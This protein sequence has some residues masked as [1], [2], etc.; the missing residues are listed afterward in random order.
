MKKIIFGAMAA[1][2]LLACSKDQVIEQNRANDEIT[3]S[4]VAENQTKA[5]A[6][7][8]NNNQPGSFNVYANHGGKAYIDGDVIEKQETSWVNTSGVRYWPESGNVTFFAHVNADGKFVGNTTA[9]TI[10]DF[11]VPTNVAAQKDLLYAVKSQ[12]KGNNPVTLNFRHAL[13]QVVFQAKNTNANLYAEISGVTI[14]NLG[15]VNTLTFPADNTDDTIVNHD[16]EGETTTTGAWGTWADLTTGTTDYSVT[17]DA[18]AVPGNS[19]VK[20][21]TNTNDTGKEYS[22]K[23]M[24]LL[25]QNRSAWVPA[26]T[27]TAADATGTYFLVNCKICNVAGADYNETNDVVLHNG[28]VA[29][30]VEIAWEQGKKYVYTFVFGNGNGGYEPDPD[31]SDPTTPSPVLVPITFNI[32]VDDFVPVANQDVEMEF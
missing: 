10:E 32:T 26:T 27:P 13:S 19:E 14:C 17:F 21:L 9:P 12:A 16:G 11:E 2:A 15:N 6:V 24:L 3:F 29:I 5:A 7:Y 18:V 30:P 25:P 31:P 4:I 8:C 1:V 20:S 23:A 22:S 28:P